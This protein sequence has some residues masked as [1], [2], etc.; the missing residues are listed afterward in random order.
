MYH[1]ILETVY[2]TLLKRKRESPA[3][4]YILNRRK[5]SRKII[6]KNDKLMI[7]DPVREK[8]PLRDCFSEKDGSSDTVLSE[9]EESHVIYILPFKTGQLDHTA[10]LTGDSLL[11]PLTKDVHGPQTGVHSFRGRRKDG[12]EPVPA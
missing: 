10:D 7:G 11:P 4:Q 12:Q 1:R 3:V 6:D 2:A 5:L 8:G 9:S